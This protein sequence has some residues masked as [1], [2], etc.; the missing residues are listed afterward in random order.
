MHFLFSSFLKHNN[1][2]LELYD[3]SDIV[4]TFKLLTLKWVG[5]VVR[6]GRRGLLIESM[7]QP[8]GKMPVGRPRRRWV[9]N[10]YGDYREHG[11][12]GMVVAGLVSQAF[13]GQWVRYF[14]S[15]KNYWPCRLVKRFLFKLCHLYMIKTIHRSIV[16][17]RKIFWQIY[18]Y[19]VSSLLTL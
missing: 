6:M 14:V 2:L 17:D 13:C 9:D 5:Q 7:S 4:K 8:I 12:S 11:R 16:E 1:E 3:K 10:I 19:S 18:I 15:L